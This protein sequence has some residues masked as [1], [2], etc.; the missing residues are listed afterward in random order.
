MW[1]NSQV[2]FSPVAGETLPVWLN[3]TTEYSRMNGVQMIVHFSGLVVNSVR[4]RQKERRLKNDL[5]TG[6]S[7][8]E[9]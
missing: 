5:K 2:A 3:N 6:K 9:G 7:G 1:Q 8:E 4:R